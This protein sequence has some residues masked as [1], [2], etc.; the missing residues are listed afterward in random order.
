MNPIF[1]CPHVGIAST[2]PTFIQK[3]DEGFEARHGVAIMGHTNMP[4]EK[5]A[6]ISPFDDDFNDNFAR[7]VGATERE[8]LADL[9]AV[10]KAIAKSLW[11]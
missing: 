8:A 7:G 9:D 3:T 2:T 11:L 4:L 10:A 6:K 1:Q 5:L